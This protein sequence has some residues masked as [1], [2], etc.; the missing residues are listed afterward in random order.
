MKV[1]ITQK[2]LHPLSSTRGIGVYAKELT[3]SL[4]K[5]YPQD[6][7]LATSDSTP[8]AGF[9]LIHY[10]FFDPFFLTLR[11]HRNIP[12]II[13][14]HDLIPLKFASHFEIGI[15]GKLKWLIQR[16]LA[17]RVNHIIT[18]SQSSKE[19]IVKILRVD[20]SKVSIIPL[21]PNQS[22]QA[23]ARLANKI[24]QV[25][26]LPPKYLLYVG[27]ISWNKNIVGLIR[28]FDLL[29]QRDLSLVLVGKAFASSPNIREFKEIRRAIDKSVRAKQIMILGY[30]PSH[31]LPV[32][33]S[34][35]TLY[36]QPS[37]YEGFGLPILEAMKFGC[38]VATSSRG[39]LPEIGGDAVAYFDPKKDIVEVI[40]SLLSSPQKLR[41]LSARAVKQAKNFSWEKTAEMTYQVYKQVISAKK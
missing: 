7:F 22:G 40:T 20:Q 10:P 38:P 31:H 5:K 14:I 17:K 33:Y 2:K 30:V 15:R 9:D 4:Q 12:T 26:K 13:T 35:A 36:V 29:P 37:W 6:K 25:Y 23:P 18:D 1:L 8:L 41:D 16:R 34:H 3:R 24:A 32:I 19:D 28:A 21:G 27:D 11:L 39:S